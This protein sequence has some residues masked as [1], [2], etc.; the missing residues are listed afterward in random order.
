M[1]EFI[2]IFSELSHGSVCIV[3]WVILIGCQNLHEDIPNGLKISLEFNSHVALLNERDV[4]LN[5][6]LNVIVKIYWFHVKREL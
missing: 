3:V 5:T 6:N 2:F 1:A 4:P